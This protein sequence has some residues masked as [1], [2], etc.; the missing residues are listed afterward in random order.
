L[1][2]IVFLILDIF[3]LCIPVTRTGETPSHLRRF[4]RKRVK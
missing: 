1:E 2:F 3:I 4:R